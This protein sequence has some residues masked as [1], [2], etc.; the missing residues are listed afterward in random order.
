[1]AKSS[2]ASKA[3]AKKG[4]KKTANGR[5]PGKILKAL[6][7]WLISPL[8]LKIY[9]ILITLFIAYVIY[10]DATIRS[11]FEGKKWQ[12]PARVYAR[13]LEL[14]EGLR[15]NADELEQELRDLGYRSGTA[16]RAGSYY[17]GGSRGND[18]TLHSRGH[19]FWDGVEQAQ[20][21]KL[22]FNGNQLSR[23]SQL[24]D[25][26]LALLR[27]EPMEIGAIYPNHREDRIL[28]KIEEVPP[29]LVA[30]L[31]AVED[32][33]FYDHHGV[34][35]SSIARAAFQNIK[36]G[37]VVQGGSTITQQLV[38][39][40]YLT[41]ERS[42][43]RKFTEAIMALL[44]ERRYDKESI[45]QAY[46]NEV[47]L[48]QAGA[49][50]IHGFGLASQHYF[51]R[52]L[53]ELSIDRLALLI[54]IVRG[55][56]YYDPWRHPERALARRNLVMDAL[57]ARELLTSQDAEW[58]KTQPLNLGK[59][60]RSHYVFPA[61]IDLVKRQLRDIYQETDLTS[62]G[63]KV[64]TNFDPR[65]QRHAEKAVVDGLKKLDAARKANTQSASEKT[66]E[67]KPLQA[68]IVV[69]Q[70]ETGDVLAIVGGNEPRYSGFNRALNAK[71]SIGSVIKPV[72]YLSA[73]LQ[74][75]QFNLATLVDDSAI[76][77]ETNGKSWSP[78]NY[79]RQDHGEVPLVIAMAKSYN[80]ATTRVG[81][82]I[83]INSVINVMQQLGFEREVNAVPSLFIGATQLSPIEVAGLYQTIA[84]NG[85]RAP[86]KAIRSVLDND[87]L[88]LDHFQYEIEQGVDSDAVHLIQHA[89]INVGRVGSAKSARQ[90]LGNDFLFA[91]KTGTS[92][93][94]RDSWFA[95][96]TGD[97]LAVV[98]LGYDNNA[99]T[100]YT[101][102]V[103]AL[104]IWTQFIR[105]ASRL[106]LSPFP[107]ANIEY[108][109]IDLETGQRSSAACKTA[110]ELPFIKNTAPAGR[111]SC[112]Y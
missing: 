31:L 15:I 21:A 56:T 52:P 61:Y 55:P 17:R 37:S 109:W 18:F 112:A 38:K 9:L 76:T 65:I 22:A 57:V 36:S 28:V 44:L 94:Q 30:A 62:N 98:W 75:E 83:G 107:S 20:T 90:V 27:L 89:L 35:P 50:A 33:R 67:D 3:K 46:L 81:Q 70:P 71:R 97:L 42:F 1:M 24:N 13:P 86:L 47:Y 63:L 92:N 25:K 87:N 101:G 39:N 102:S 69:T 79:D 100:A 84:A 108:Q 26:P 43:S 68:A 6:L 10:L 49:R 16:T 40:Y 85:Y 77:I 110:T 5:S 58:A 34:S 93:E 99:P 103:G 32:H 41:R 78:R 8:A 4:Q 66:T 12:L 80:Q 19:I 54:A 106:P 88:P 2:N 51:N 74:P 95:G 64:Y 91:G 105:S 48:G 59:K 7:R 82:Q 29:L 60:T 23:V 14:Y 104:P 53:H 45:L 111:P 96:F 73:L 11:S 72:V